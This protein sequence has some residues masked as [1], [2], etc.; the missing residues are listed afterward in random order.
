[1]KSV[2]KVPLLGDIPV[3][4]WLFRDNST[5]KQR[6]NLLLFLTPYIIRD[7]SDFR[8]IFERKMRERQEFVEQFYGR[9]PGY[10]VAVDY[11]RKAGPLAKMFKS[12]DQEAAKLE[13]GGPGSGSEKL[14][15][16]RGA[17]PMPPPG[18]VVEPRGT[19]KVNPNPK[20]PRGTA[21]APEP[22][23]K[24]TPPGEPA[25]APE[26]KEPPASQP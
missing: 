2:Q 16:P 9:Q 14:F 25:K 23:L 20:A 17:L 7:Q 6:T 8:R 21:P 22:E 12:L 26:V 4:G 19:T 18:T 5:T 3:L 15:T 10:R 13:N 11:T 24:S 1:V